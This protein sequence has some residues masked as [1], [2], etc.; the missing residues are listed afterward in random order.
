VDGKITL[1]VRNFDTVETREI[2]YAG[3]LRYPH[4]ERIAGRQDY[5]GEILTAR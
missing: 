3:G 1:L 5:L 4:L 2:A